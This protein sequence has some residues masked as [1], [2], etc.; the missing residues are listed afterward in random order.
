MII[1][2]QG[3]Q[4]GDPLGPAL[5]SLV[6]HSQAKQMKF[7]LSLW[8]LDDATMGDQPATVLQDLSTLIASSGALGME[9]M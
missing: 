6:A 4:Q 2:Q 1:S 3:V 8:Y 5:F 9:Q 7:H